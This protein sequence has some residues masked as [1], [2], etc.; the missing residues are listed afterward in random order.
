TTG[1]RTLTKLPSRTEIEAWLFRGCAVG[2]PETGCFRARPSSRSRSGWLPWVARWS[3]RWTRRAPSWAWT[4]PT[5]S[6]T[7]PPPMRYR[8]ALR[9]W[10]SCGLRK[11]TPGGIAGPWATEFAERLDADTRPHDTKGTEMTDSIKVDPKNNMIY[12]G[13]REW[14][15]T[16]E[17]HGVPTD[18][19]T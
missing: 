12:G 13:D 4:S 16:I 7:T 11:T 19:A 14:L 2:C 1:R 5:R 9:P 17:K 15:D 10:R 3:W 6:T 8:S 18:S